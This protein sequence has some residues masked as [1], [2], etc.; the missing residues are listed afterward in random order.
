MPKKPEEKKEPEVKLEVNKELA[1]VKVLTAHS[2]PHGSFTKGDT[3]ILEKSIAL[4]L[5]RCGYAK[6]LSTATGVETATDP[7]TVEKR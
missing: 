5:E 1:Q 6:V 2:G 3:P 4:E 7:E